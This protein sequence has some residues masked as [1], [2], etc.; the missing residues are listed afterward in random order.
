MNAQSH[1]FG[2][3]TI[4]LEVNSFHLLEIATNLSKILKTSCI[5]IATIM[6]FRMTIIHQL[7]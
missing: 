4:L 7:N 3:S 6:T 1:I 2:D 5:F